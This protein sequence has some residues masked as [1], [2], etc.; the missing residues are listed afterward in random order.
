MTKTTNVFLTG[1]MLIALFLSACAG[2]AVKESEDKKEGS[3]TESVSEESDD[4]TTEK[5]EEALPTKDTSKLITTKSAGKVKLGV[6]VAKVREAIKPLTLKRESDGEGIAL[7]AVQK[8]NKM[9]MLIYAGE[10]DPDAA[11]NDKAIVEQIEVFDS[12]FK[13]EKGVHPGMKI[14]DAEAK[15]GKVKEIM[16]S[17]IESREYAEFVNQPK[18]LLFRLTST[19]G[20][21][22]I[23]GKGNNKTTKYTQ[24]AKVDTVTVLKPFES[25][26]T[27]DAKFTSSYTS[28]S[29]GCK[30][31]GG[32]EG[33]HVSTICKGP[34]GYQINYFDTA[35]TLQFAVETSDGKNSIDLASQDMSYDT[36]KGKVEFRLADGKP[37][38]V[39]MRTYGKNKKQNLVVKGLKG[40]ESINSKIDVRKTKNANEAARKA[41]DEGYSK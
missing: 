37:F 18:G 4:T 34:G 17:E 20:Q 11:I 5:D 32:E 13:T 6:S 30:S 41:A 38:A 29:D 7:I 14:G 24:N 19:D 8:G 10:E 1:L 12:S 9:L 3:G 15:Y 25:D 40:F 28:L 16:L 23:Y 35:S 27:S 36:K 22:G 26:E 21:A 31:T 39:I 2:T 33:G